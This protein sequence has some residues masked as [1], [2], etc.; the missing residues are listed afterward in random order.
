MHIVVEGN[1]CTGKTS[2]AKGLARDLESIGCP[3]AYLKLLLSEKKKPEVDE[4]RM[5]GASDSEITALYL[6]DIYES[7]EIASEEIRAGKWV[8]MDRYIPSLL[9]YTHAK[10]PGGYNQLLQSIDH[11]RILMPNVMF[12]LRASTET[13]KAR[14]G[15]KTDTSQFD[16][17]NILNSDLETFLIEE[18][19][20]YNPVEILTDNL[21]L[22]EVRRFAERILNIGGI[23]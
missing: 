14:L 9:A 19:K 21:S 17:D 12:F 18:S 15:S 23:Q 4:A 8:V 3:V 6:E 13:K 1:M 10:E 2:L 16:L 5:L 20:I 7:N 11:S 22:E